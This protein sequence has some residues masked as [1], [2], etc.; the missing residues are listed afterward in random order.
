VSDTGDGQLR[1]S[2]GG[3]KRP[4]DRVDYSG[5]GCDTG[6]VPWTAQEV[7]VPVATGY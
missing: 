6:T 1:S 7:V 3:L 4:V 2:R 5:A